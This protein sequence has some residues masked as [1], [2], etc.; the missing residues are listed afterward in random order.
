MFQ[1]FEIQIF[2]DYS[3]GQ[4]RVSYRT[5]THPH[6]HLPTR[7]TPHPAMHQLLIIT[8]TQAHLQEIFLAAAC[9][10]MTRLPQLIILINP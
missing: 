10:N 4:G 3:S 2:H 9:L 1:C 8:Q 7:P 5:G 6:N